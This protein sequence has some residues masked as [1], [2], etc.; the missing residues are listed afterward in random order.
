MFIRIRKAEQPHTTTK[1]EP[2]GPCTIGLAILY[3]HIRK[4]TNLHL[5]NIWHTFIHWEWPVRRGA[6]RVG[7]IH[8]ATEHQRFQVISITWPSPL[9][10]H[11]RMQFHV[12]SETYSWFLIVRGKTCQDAFNTIL[13]RL[14]SCGFLVSSSRLKGAV[15]WPLQCLTLSRQ[16][17]RPGYARITNDIINDYIHSADPECKNAVDALAARQHSNF[18]SLWRADKSNQRWKSH[19]KIRKGVYWDFHP[20]LFGCYS[21]WP[22][23]RL[24]PCSRL[25]VHADLRLFM[26]F[27]CFRLSSF[28]PMDWSSATT[29][30]ES[31]QPPLS[32]MEN[33]GPISCCHRWS[34]GARHGQVGDSHRYIGTTSTAQVSMESFGGESDV[35]WSLNI[36]M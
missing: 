35:E 22:Q 12:V 29:R 9:E 18:N 20:M 4:Y 8:Q 11:S 14:G 19:R 6:E 31:K 17:T 25:F 26:A 13:L 7:P 2:S 15:Q 27:L 3:G 10:L 32:R 23:A 34:S 21:C 16:E 28:Y 30:S 33:L 5:R 36:G 24:P 1:T